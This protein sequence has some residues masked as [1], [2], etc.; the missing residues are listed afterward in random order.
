[1]DKNLSRKLCELLSI[2]KRETTPFHLAGNGQIERF[3]STFSAMM[4][5]LV[6][7]NR[8]IWEN[9][10]PY[11]AFA[12]YNTVHASTNFTPHYLVTGREAMVPFD[13]AYPIALPRS[14][15]EN[16][17]VAELTAEYMAHA[18]SLARDNIAAAQSSYKFYHDKLL[19]GRKVGLNDVVYVSVPVS[20]PGTV[21]KFAR[22]FKGPYRVGLNV[23]VRALNEHHKEVGSEFVVHLERVKL[24]RAPITEYDTPTYVSRKT[25]AK[26]DRTDR[27]LNADRMGA[28]QETTGNFTFGILLSRLIEL[29]I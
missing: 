23:V 12:Y 15:G 28:N 4:S 7:K 19:Q 26:V 29:V 27:G 5:T 2:K 21:K 10:L 20:K 24:A 22:G 11:V 17:S 25:N 9:L 1:M 13:V 6:E 8:S 18:W 3:F 16:K 14:Y